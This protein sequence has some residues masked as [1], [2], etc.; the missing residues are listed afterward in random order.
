MTQITRCFAFAAALV[1]FGGCG[2]QSLVIDEDTG[3]P[4]FS[5]ET[6]IDAPSETLTPAQTE[7]PTPTLTETSAPTNAPT[8]IPPLATSPPSELLDFTSPLLDPFGFPFFD[9]ADTP[10]LFS[11]L[12]DSLMFD[13]V[14][15][16]DRGGLADDYT[17]LEL[18]CLEGDDPDFICRQ[19][20]GR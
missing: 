2:A 10:D 7:T 12:L 3:D 11:L 20:Y 15:P 9:L 6:P 18:L 5:A 1:L 17:H 19:R 8:P 16:A 13:I 4:P 14:L